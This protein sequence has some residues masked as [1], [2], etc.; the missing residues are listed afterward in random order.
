MADR[1]EIYVLDMGKP[2][3]IL[4][5]AENLIRLSGYEP[6]RDIDI[7]EVGLRPGEKL[8]EELLIQGE[9]LSTTSNEM[10]FVERQ[11]PIDPDQV[12]RDL[13]E[14]DRA[15]TEKTSPQELILLLRS[16]IPTY[17]SPEEVNAAAEEH[18]AAAL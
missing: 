2:V 18:T 5:L 8:Y 7:K 6:Y 1:N 13:K 15:V 9:T 10:I 17:R 3:K 12:M 14:L 11:M 16:M 4:T